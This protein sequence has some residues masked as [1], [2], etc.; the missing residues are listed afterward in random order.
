[1]G[2]PYAEVIGD[3]IGHSKSPLIHNFWLQKSACPGDF[4]TTRVTAG[5][6]SS[7]LERG[8][9]DPFW[10]G[11]SVTTPLKREAAALL[12]DP[13]GICSWI[14]AVNCVFR[15]ALGLVPAN[16]DIAGVDSALAGIRLEGE[17]VCLIGAG[18]A[19]AAALCYLIG[20]RPG[21]IVLIARDPAKA[22]ALRERAPL[23]ARNLIEVVPLPDAASPIRSSILTVNATPM[24]MENG[25]VIAQSILEGVSGARGGATIFDMVYAPADTPLLRTARE[26]GLGSVGGLKMLVGQAAPAFEMFFGVPAPREHDSE[27]LELLAS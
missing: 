18:G 6:L 3:P 27:L 26:R 14:G 10:R 7:H 24:G 11:C 21:A 8:R 12:G 4:R 15:S 20:R 9:A 25:P 13:T 23:S 16:S 22:A 1:M 5:S 2:I 19:A 17:K